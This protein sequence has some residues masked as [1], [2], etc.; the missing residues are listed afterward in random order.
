MSFEC[1]D[2][3]G[4]RLDSIPVKDLFMEARLRATLRPT[5]TIEGLVTR[6]TLL[7]LTVSSIDHTTD[8]ETLSST[9]FDYQHFVDVKLRHVVRPARLLDWAHLEWVEV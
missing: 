3:S 8:G 1:H 9:V 2:I 4:A 6:L 7:I 5:P